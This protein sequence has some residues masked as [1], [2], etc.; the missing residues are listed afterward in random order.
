MSLDTKYRP[1]R[2]AD[3]LG[4]DATIKVCREYVRSGHGFRQSYVFAGPWGGGKTTLARIL[5]RAL[6]C[7][8]PQEGEPC[9]R[10]H[11]CRSMLDDRP[12]AFVEVDAATNS[13][14]ED[15]KRITDEVRYGTFSGRRKIYLLDESHEL[16]RQ[17]M[18]AMLKPLED[19]VRGT[20][21]K[22]LVCIFCTTEPE[23][24]RKAILSRCA[25]VFRIRTNTPDE[26]VVRLDY[27]CEM[28]GIEREKDA[29]RLIAEVT[30]CHVRD[31][32]KA[33]EGVSML[34][35]ISRANVETYLL[36][37]ANALYL[38]LLDRVGV[39]LAGALEVLERLGQKVSPATCYEKLAD[40]CMLAYRLSRLGSTVV[41]SYWDAARLAALGTNHGHHLV[42][43]A[44]RFA[45]RPGQPTMSM[46]TCD[47]AMLHR[48]R[49]GEVVRVDPV[50]VSVPPPAIAPSPPPAAPPRSPDSP[51]SAST[52]AGPT[53]DTVSREPERAE[54]ASRSEAPGSMRRD[55]VVT[56][57]TG[58]YVDPKAQRNARH[59]AEHRSP[60]NG[61][62]SSL[63]PSAFTQYL[64]QWVLELIEEK[65]TSGRPSR[66]DDL[67]SP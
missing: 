3:V 23:K 48:Q 32:I 63:S 58:T 6:L 11:Q 34:G 22:Q 28:E 47:I 43:F 42:D 27:V 18:D 50:V 39:D 52:V 65:S 19:N 44:Q 45:Q 21:D 8:D 54:V 56:E 62:S 1:V 51:A 59:V 35:G 60:T 25:P 67:G 49:S 24:M 15:V 38:D 12:E 46:L 7:D 36:L 2:Y 5:A 26:I 64:R 4:Q 16:S 40:L 20:Q 57:G 61:A 30:E 53:V 10:C 33:V 55:P 66:R 13:G 37:D 14:K 17:A 29:L 9:D 31:A 41:P